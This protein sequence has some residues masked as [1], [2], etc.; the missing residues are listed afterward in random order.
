MWIFIKRCFLYVNLFFQV[1][2][3]LASG[4]GN[5]Q[6]TSLLANSSHNTYNFHHMSECK[7]N[8]FYD[9]DTFSC[10]AC[11]KEEENLQS[12]PDSKYWLNR[13]KYTTN[14]LRIWNLKCSYMCSGLCT[15]YHTYRIYVGMY[16]CELRCTY[17]PCSQINWLYITTSMRC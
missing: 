17:L 8:E 7:H 10:V 1:L 2:A 9:L 6:T 5:V 16:L 12:T 13:F 3:A 11:G 4:P 15:T 14:Y